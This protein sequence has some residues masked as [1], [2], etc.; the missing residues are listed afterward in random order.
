MNVTCP[1]IVKFAPIALG[2]DA[3]Q[4]ASGVC[5][6]EVVDTGDHAGEGPAPE[7]R[8]TDESGLRRP[9]ASRPG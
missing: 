7:R 6:F 5:G 2:L 3:G 9:G 8:E 1:T 4:A